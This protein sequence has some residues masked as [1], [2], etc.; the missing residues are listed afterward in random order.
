MTELSLPIEYSITGFSLSATTSRMMWMLSA[1]SRSRWVNIVRL[2]V[3]CRRRA[4][5]AAL[6]AWRQRYRA[7]GMPLFVRVD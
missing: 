5:C 1:S 3:S 7:G 2:L 4:T 6:R